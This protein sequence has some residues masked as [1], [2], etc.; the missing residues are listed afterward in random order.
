MAFDDI[1][2]ALNELRVTS[3]AQPKPK[4]VYENDEVDSALRTLRGEDPVD[5]TSLTPVPIPPR[6]P[7][8]EQVD[9]D[10]LSINLRR[11]AEAN[12]TQA[13][14]DDA[15]SRALNVPIELLPKDADVQAYFSA[16]NPQA[17]LRDFPEIANYLNQGQNAALNGRNIEN[18]KAIRTSLKRATVDPVITAAKGTIAVPEF[19][20]GVADL[21]SKGKAGKAVQDAGINFKDFKGRLDTLYTDEQKE[22]NRKTAQAEGFLDTIGTA[23]E[24]PSTITHAVTESIPSM[25]SGGAVGRLIKRFFP[26]VSA[27]VAG[28]AG[29]GTVIAGSQAERIRQET[30]TGELTGGQALLAAGAGVAGGAIGVL[31][32]KLMQRMGFGD[33]DTALAGRQLQKALDTSQVPK[34]MASRILAGGVSEGV[35]EEMPQSAI[36]QITENIALG[37]KWDENV[38]NAA[39]MGLLTGTPLGA[40]FGAVSGAAQPTEAANQLDAA[41]TGAIREFAKAAQAEESMTKIDALMKASAENP[42][43]KDSPES[44][45]EFVRTMADEDDSINDVYVDGETL[46]N[47]LNQSDIDLSKQIPGLARDIQVARETKGDV[48]ISIEDFATHFAGTKAGEQLLASVKT[49]PEGMTFSEAQGFQQSQIKEFEKQAQEIVDTHNPVLSRA[50]FDTQNPGGDYATYL[51]EHTNTVEAFTA[52]AQRVHDEILAGMNQAGRFNKAVNRLYAIPFR[53]FYAVNA[54]REGIMPSELFKRLPLNFSKMS[55]N[56]GFTQRE[57]QPGSMTVMGVHFSKEH[58]ESLQGKFVGTGM[59]AAERDRLFMATDPR[60]KNRIDFYTDTGSGVKPE[61]GLGSVRHDVLLN[62]I[63]D[64][65]TNPLG[66]KVPYKPG[67]TGMNDFESQVIDAGF[68]G[69]FIQQGNQGRVVILGDA[70]NNI[71]TGGQNGLGQ[72]GIPA[73]TI[74]QNPVA[75]EADGSLQGLPRKV[76]EFTASSFEKAQEVTRQYMKKAGLEYNPPNSYVKVDPARAKRIADAFDAMEHSPSDPDVK[77]AY[78]ALVKE[79]AAQYQAVM[80]SGLVVEFIDGPD[81]YAGNPRAMTDDVRNNNHMW[82]Y[83]TRQGFGSDASF[84]PADNPLLGETDFEISGQKALVNDLFRVVHDYFGHVKEGVGFRADGEENAWRAHVSMFSPLAARAVTT[85]TRGQNSWVNFGPFGEANKKASAENTHYADQKI[86]LLPEWVT[87]EGAGDAGVLNQSVRLMNKTENLK[88]FGL[89]PD[90]SYTTRQVAAAL[91]ARQRAKYGTIEAGDYSPEAMKKISSWMAEEVAFEMDNPQESGV[92]WYSEKFQR[93]LNELGRKYPELLTDKNARNTFTALIAITSDGQKVTTNLNL[94]SDIYGRYASTGKFTVSG[95]QTVSVPGNLKALQDLYDRMGVEKAHEFLLSEKT[96]SELKKLAAEHGHTLTS[97]YQADFML[98]MAALAFGPKL[99]AF[100][101]NLMGSHGYLTM[102]RWWSRTFNRY[103]GTLLMEPTKSSLA[104]FRGLIGQE[105]LSDDETIAASVA[106]R[107]AYEQRGFKTRLAQL[108]GSSEPTTDKAKATWMAKAKEKAGDQFVDLLAEH[109]I[110]RAAN[111]IYKKAFENLED[112]PFGAKDRTFMTDATK[113][114]QKKLKARGLDIS[115]A[116]IQAILWYYEKKLYGKMGAKQSGVISYE[117]AARRLVNGET[118]GTDIEPGAGT[119]AAGMGIGEVSI[120]NES[121]N[122]DLNQSAF[123]SALEREIPGLQKIGDKQGMIQPH[124]A[125]KWVESRQREGKFKKEEVEAI[126]LIDWLEVQ[127][128]KIAVA[129]IENFVRENGVQVE[130]TVL[131]GSEI[132]E[133]DSGEQA[134]EEILNSVEVSDYDENDEPDMWQFRYKGVVY[135]SGIDPFE[136][137]RRDLLDKVGFIPEIKP[138]TEYASFVLPGGENYKELLL[139]LPGRTLFKAPHFEEAGN[140]NIIAHTRID[141]RV[142]EVPLTDEQ[143]AALDKYEKDYAAIN[144]EAKP[145]LARR[146]VAADAYEAELKRIVKETGLPVTEVLDNMP[147]SLKDAAAESEAALAAVKDFSAR[148]PVRPQFTKTKQRVLFV[149]EIQSDWAQQGRDRGFKRPRTKELQ[150]LRVEQSKLIAQIKED[151]GRSSVTT[152]DEENNPR[153][154]EINSKIAELEKGLGPTPIGPFVQD[155]K[156]WT[157]LIVKRLMRYAAEN[158]FDRIAWTTGAQQN[159]RYNL[160]D[161]ITKIKTRLGP[162]GYYVRADDTQGRTMIADYYSAEELPGVVGQSIADKIIEQAIE[163]EDVVISGIELEVGGDGMKSF[164]D[165]IVPSVFNDVSKKLGG[166]KVDQINFGETF[167][168]YLKRR[169]LFVNPS[170]GKVYTSPSFDP[171]TKTLDTLNEIRKQ[172]ETSPDVRKGP[173]VQQSITITP[174]MRDKIMQGLPLFQGQR[175][176]YNP[177]S[178]TISL[179]QG[180]DLSSVIHEGG[181]FYLEALRDMASQPNAP[182]QIKDDFEKTLKWFGVANETQWDSMTLDQRRPYHEQWAQSFERYTLEGKAPTVEMQPVFQRFRAWMLNIYKSLQEFL[183]QNPLAGKLNDDIRGVFDRLIANENEIARTEKLRSYAPLFADAESAGLTEKQY[184]DYLALGKQATQDAADKLNSRSIRDMKWLSGARSRALRSLQAEAKAKRKLIRAEVTQEIAQEP[185]ERAKLFLSKGQYI[186]DQGQVIE[187]IVKAKL[188]LAEVKKLK[189]SFNPNDLR[190]MTAEDGLGLDVAGQMFGYTSGEALLDDLLTTDPTR[191][192]IQGRTDQRMLEE[193]G[194]LVDDRALENAADEAVHNEARARFM[195]TGL[196]ILT[197]KKTRDEGRQLTKAA[198]QAAESVIAAKLIREIQPGQ[199]AAAETRANK[200]A[201]K[202]APK[203]KAKAAEAQRAALLNNKLYATAR[204]AKTEV[205]QILRY[206]KKFDNNRKPNRPIDF[207]YIEQINDLLRPFNFKNISLKEID[208]SKTLAEWVNEQEANGFQPALNVDTLERVK[209]TKKSYKDMTL[210]EL[211]GLRDAVKQIE[212]IGRLKHK[213]LT[214]R[215]RAAFQERIDEADQSIRDNANRTV[216]ER[217]TPTDITGRTGQWFRQAAAS[218]RK[219][220]SVMRE[221]DGGENNGVMWNLLS[222]GMNDAGNQ[223]TEMR[224]QAAQKMAELFKMIKLE[225]GFANLYAKKR[226]VPGTNLS[227]THEQRIMFGMNWGNEG[228]R[229]RLLDGGMSGQRA[230]S[231][232]EAQAILDTLTQPEWDFIQA[233]LDYIGT[234]KDQIAALEKQLTGVEPIW[235][236][237]S[238]IKTKFGNYKGGY[239]PAK[240]DAELSSR[241]EAFEAMTDLRMGMKGIFNA[242]ATR[243]GYTQERSKQVI[244]RPILLSFDVIPTHVNEVI[245]RL[246]W[247]PWL[248]DAN[249]ILKALDIPIREHYGPEILRELRNTVTDIAA[250]DASAKNAWEASINHLRVGSTIIGMGWKV[251]TALLQ[252]TGLAQTYVRI[253]PKWATKGVLQFLGSPLK[254]AELVDSKSSMMRNRGITMQR[255]VNEVLNTLRA[256]ET[257]SNVKASYFLLI[258]KMQRMVDIPTWIGAYEGALESLKYENALDEKQ[259]KDIEEQAS[260]LADQAVIDSQSGGM[261][262]DLAAIQRGSPLQKLFTNFFSYFSATYNLNVEAV[263]K[264]NFYKPSEVGILGVNL[265]MLNIVPVIFSLALKEA[266]KGECGDDLECLTGKLI[267]EQI[268]FLFGQMVGLREL[269]VGATELAKLSG[270]EGIESYGYQGPAGLRFFTDFAKAGKQ[271][272]QG[273]LDLPLFKSVNNTL[274]A[275]FHYPAGQINNTVAGIIAVEEGQVEGVSIL[276]ALVFGPPKE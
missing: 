121:Y 116:D 260:A 120:G 67:N 27:L 53:E 39:A 30:E 222:R 2:A 94:A 142:I 65:S 122:P 96:L 138:G 243:H 22:A 28:A 246:S 203:D 49:D 13:A 11:A 124:Q 106:P 97:P 139:K 252:P 26:S 192:K 198:K 15:L 114:A 131:E 16:S 42:L 43:R 249:R 108:V 259:R 133:E 270:V 272:A 240:Y 87:T 159:A 101:A 220:S 125:M 117:E 175:A 50:E 130:E 56:Q 8:K 136:M 48:R 102:D 210:D 40:T 119:E 244:G 154:A 273:E 258:G 151:T 59:P 71:P 226:V 204:D 58:R 157:A 268:S 173:G 148:V 262:K 199:Y 193:H 61:S 147:Q 190:G 10:R 134:V 212:H 85:E 187:A 20:V 75:R 93:A 57:P 172:F 45:K 239:F 225:Q 218:F 73:T 63:Y 158:G 253:G 35:L 181:H 238:E 81:P 250:G 23:L 216:E 109:N 78:D 248:T 156:S 206:V 169:N 256:G 229:Q 62:N 6:K 143:Q 217:G 145:A 237:P 34:G 37:K 245:H 33:I 234:Y 219:F 21:L 160:A 242:A 195:A 257:A 224:Q 95:Q 164:Y 171:R 38:G 276:P 110:E 128:G 205:D 233:T 221:M 99:G 115:I 4:Q 107:D 129:D 126:G 236:E 230:I 3:P 113:A 9:L 141:E 264:T 64:G 275:V 211:R 196:S 31:S 191:E 209:N 263:R 132:T 76:G 254:S 7:N 140:E 51:K 54:A 77:A 168:Q 150:D 36:E 267:Q 167:E 90:K 215:D 165:R 207:E 235:I 200:E 179:L 214:A 70:A 69:Y 100:Y 255:E 185:V 152:A 123:Y 266:T 82:V 41:A 197:G 1:D 241:S 265:I 153:L 24:N 14:R 202:Q 137:S 247:Q 17:L 269:S 201:L 261:T 146:R 79:T 231:R 227:M 188:N 189:P 84:D 271:I 144:E 105:G 60:I 232:P 68:D 12:P 83:S 163:N 155:T 166:G 112:A 29:E 149:E 25:L 91:E 223:E 52:D 89:D 5:A 186:D 183:R 80:D 19:L 274:G 74:R 251:S 104:T 213:L 66:F 47:V 208:K 111:T 170:D 98:P 127:E 86:G 178:F 88:K 92:G 72:T 228:N 118:I 103:R 32:A 184:D 55:I 162:N 174:E 194:D 18:L 182:Q 135:D 177:Q 176:G 161:K 44:F 180:S 46:Q